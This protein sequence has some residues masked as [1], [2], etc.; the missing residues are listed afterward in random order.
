MIRHFDKQGR[1][2]TRDEYGRKMEDWD[3]KR[4]ARTEIGKV[5]V[6]TVWLGLD[7]NHTGRGPPLIFE[8]MVFGAKEE[9][10]CERYSTQAEALD[11]H[12]AAVA[13]WSP[14]E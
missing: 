13:K 12:E 8:T 10:H 4:V 11:G 7:H 5:V 14:R 9:E 3:Y 2:I 1:P 6:S